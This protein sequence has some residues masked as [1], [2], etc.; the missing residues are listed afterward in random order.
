MIEQAVASG[1]LGAVKTSLPKGRHIL[2]SD[3]KSEKELATVREGTKR[4]NIPAERRTLIKPQEGKKE[5]MV[6]SRNLKEFNTAGSLTDPCFGV[7]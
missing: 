2:T 1:Y 5:G 4:K 7:N 6:F 3:L